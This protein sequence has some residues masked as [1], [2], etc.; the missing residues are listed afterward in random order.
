MISN[1]QLT[2]L[3]DA[4]RTAERATTKLRTGAVLVRNSNNVISRGAS[5]WERQVWNGSLLSLTGHAELMA[6]L[7]S[8]RHARRLFGSLVS[9][10]A[11]SL[12]I[13][14]EKRQGVL[15]S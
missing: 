5:M 12:P 14:K 7:D 15:C 8:S 11:S 13:P 6:I 4:A 9:I 2:H 1:R 10:Y 3:I